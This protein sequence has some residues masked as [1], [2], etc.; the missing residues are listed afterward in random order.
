M[1]SLKEVTPSS[2]TIRSISISTWSVSSHTI[3]WK[4]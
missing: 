2:R 3:M 1:K 4:P